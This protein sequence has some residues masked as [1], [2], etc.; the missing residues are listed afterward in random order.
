MFKKKVGQ[1]A[2]PLFFVFVVHRN[3]NEIFYLSTM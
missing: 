1:T 2:F 3:G